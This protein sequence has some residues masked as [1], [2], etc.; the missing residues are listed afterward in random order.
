MVFSHPAGDESPQVQAG[1]ISLTFNVF[2]SVRPLTPHMSAN[3]PSGLGLCLLCLR[4]FLV[5]VI[6]QVCAGFVCVLMLWL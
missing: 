2:R 1:G 3:A 5:F 4:A 6:S